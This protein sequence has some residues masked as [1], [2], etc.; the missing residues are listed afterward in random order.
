MSQIQITNLS[1]R[2]PGQTD[3]IFKNVNLTLDTDWKLGLIGRNGSGKT[4]LLKLLLGEYE[5]NN[6]IGKNVEFEYFPF[7]IKDE[8]V[9]TMDIAYDIIPNLEEWKVFK[10]LN[11]IQMDADILYR[12]F[13]SL[14]GGEKVKFLLICAFLKENKFLLIDEPTNHIDE[15]SKETLSSYLKKKKGFILVSHDRKIL[16]EVV[17]HILYIGRQNITLEQGNYD[18][19]NFNKTNKDNNEIEQNERLRKD[20]MKLDKTAKQTADWSNAV[21]KSKKGAVD[22]GHVGHQ[23][24]KM[25]KRAKV[26][27][28]RR[29]KK[30]E[31]KSN[32]L[33]DV[34][35]NPDLQMKPLTPSRRNLI[36]A[37]NLSIFYGKKIIFDNVSFHVDVGDRVAIKGNNGSGNSCIL[38]LIIGE[39]I[40]NN[41]ALKIMP[42][43]KISYVS[44]TTEEVKGTISEYARKNSVDE[45]IFRAMLQKLGVDKDK[46]EKDLADL[47][48]GQKKKVMIARSITDDSEIYIWDEPLNYLDIQSREQIENMIIKYQPTMLFIEHD[49]VF[50]NKIATKVIE[51]GKEEK[52]I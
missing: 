18:S 48:E 28:N 31:E 16:N 52:N 13:S 9:M 10:E 37:Q 32:L 4:T 36:L 24:A 14:S 22:K 2:H 3:Y 50:I 12:K 30:I 43:I 51:L 25:M 47:S 39:H 17:D 6:A 8:D 45:G 1:F 38:Y 23:A 29:D 27:E 26:L 46:L 20:I 7:E 21:E 19:W 35:N 33:I 40:P 34:D 49:D 42:K 44:Q 11:L 15:K 5:S 41:N